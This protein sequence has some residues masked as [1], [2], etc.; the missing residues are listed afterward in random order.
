MV[1]FTNLCR[2]EY[3]IIFNTQKKHTNRENIYFYQ[4]INMKTTR[5][6]EYN[7][8]LPI[9][10]HNYEDLYANNYRLFPKRKEMEEEGV[11]LKE[12]G[13]RRNTRKRGGPN[14]TVATHGS[15]D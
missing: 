4:K 7:D 1:D 9:Y 12:E 11:Y 10:M 8:D 5:S 3:F 2:H 14:G 15:G 13:K 6:T